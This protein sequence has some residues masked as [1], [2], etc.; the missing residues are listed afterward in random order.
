MYVTRRRSVTFMCYKKFL[1]K[2]VLR[3]FNYVTVYFNVFP[4]PTCALLND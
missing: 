4:S 1:L 2:N 3:A